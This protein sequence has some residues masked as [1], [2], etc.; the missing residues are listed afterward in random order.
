[1]TFLQKYSRSIFCLLATAIWLSVA[2]GAFSLMFDTRFLRY[3]PTLLAAGFAATYIVA[4]FLIRLTPGGEKIFSALLVTLAAPFSPVLSIVAAG[5]LI[6]FATEA[7]G[8]QN[9]AGK[10]IILPAAATLIA[11]LTFIGLYVIS[12]KSFFYQPG[13]LKKQM[14]LVLIICTTPLFAFIEKPCFSDIACMIEKDRKAEEKLISRERI[15]NVKKYISKQ[16]VFSNDI[17]DIKDI[18]IYDAHSQGFLDMITTFEMR[19]Y[20]TKGYGT[21]SYR[22][23]YCIPISKT[24]PWKVSGKE[25]IYLFR[26]EAEFGNDLQIDTYT[27][28]ER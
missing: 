11:V 25:T 22:D 20:G 7:G 24:C 10:A 4:F 26:D 1:M 2:V 18:Y 5:S 28:K 13:Y 14:I 19:I 15:A 6:T 8:I 21:F 12:R 27:K 16:K 23:G 9:D 3:L 17:G